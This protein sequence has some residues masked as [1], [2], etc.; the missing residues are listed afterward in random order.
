MA[1]SAV[2]KGY[3]SVTPYL[4]A[5]DARALIDF[6]KQAFEFDRHDLGAILLALAAPLGVF[7]IVELALDPAFG[8][9]EEVGEGPAQ[10]FQVGFEPGVDH[11]GD[12]GI[13]HVGDGASGNAFFGERSRIGFV[14]QGAIA[15]E[16]DFIE[17][18]GCG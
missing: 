17:E 3:H 10:V 14:G 11:G 6:A 4:I 13:E 18:M 5:K 2:P 1:V 8:T 9:V 16:G 15:V 12:E 7:V